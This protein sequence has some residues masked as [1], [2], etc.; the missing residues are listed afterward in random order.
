MSKKKYEFV[1]FDDCKVDLDAYA[2]LAD[3]GLTYDAHGYVVPLPPKE[4][5]AEAQ[6]VSCDGTNGSQE[7]NPLQG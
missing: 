7:S 3:Q 2:R 4:A 1:D 5:T 6:G